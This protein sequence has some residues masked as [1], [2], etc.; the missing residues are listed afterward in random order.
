MIDPVMGAWGIIRRLTFDSEV[1]Y[2]G[3]TFA[4]NPAE[5][6][7]IG[8]SPDLRAIAKK[9]YL[10][11]LHTKTGAPVFPGYPKWSNGRED[12]SVR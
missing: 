8:Y 4:K 5:R 12:E 3:V 7:L 10:Q 9:T 1:W 2:R 6:T 11:H